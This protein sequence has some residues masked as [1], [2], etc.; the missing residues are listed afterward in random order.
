MYNMSRS[1]VRIFFR[2]M[3]VLDSLTFKGSN[4]SNPL[5]FLQQLDGIRLQAQRRLNKNRQSDWGQFFTSPKI[6]AMMGN[7]FTNFPSTIHLLDAGA[8]VGTLTAA[9]IAQVIESKSGVKEI[10]VTAYELDQ[11]LLYD[12]NITLKKCSEL[13]IKSGVEFQYEIQQK[14]FILDIA[15]ALLKKHTLF[16]EKHIE[17]SHAIMNP[18]YKKI[19]SQSKTR[20]VLNSIGIQTTNLYTAFVWLATEILKPEGEMVV[21]IPRS[22]CNGSY[23]KNFRVHFLRTMAIKQIHIFDSRDNLFKENNVLQENVIV[24][25]KKSDQQI[26]KI[27]ITQSNDPDDD[28]T[29]NFIDY[30]QLVQPDDP[31]FFIRLISNGLE[32]KI[33]STINDLN[34]TLIDLELEVS[35]GR[36]VDFRAEEWLRLESTLETVPLIYPLNIKN[37]RVTWSPKGTKKPSA[38]ISSH[39][40]D[41]LLVPSQNYVLVKRFSSKE[42]KRRV[43]AA[44][45]DPAAINA[46]KIG[47]ENHLNYFYH[48][49]KELSTDFAKG[50]T[51]YLNSTLVD[52]YFRQFSGHTQINASDLRK[53]KYPSQ[54]QLIAMGRQVSNIFP[55]QDEIDRIVSKELELNKE[56][57]LKSQ[58]P[59][60]AKKKIRE[61]LSILK[62][63]NVP[64]AQQNDR[65]ALALL[66]LLNIR[67]DTSW[68][69]ASQNLIGITE[70]MDFFR[71]HY[72]V[73]YAPNTRET[74]RRQTIH[75]FIQLGLVIPNP[76]D[77]TRPINSPKTR[78]VIGTQVMEEI[79]NFESPQWNQQISSFILNT[80]SLQNLQV[81]ERSMPMIPVTLPDGNSLMI[82]SG[83]QNEL[84]K[85]ILEEFCPRFTPGGKVVYIGD[86][87]E[88]LNA[89]EFRYLENL[90]LHIDK[91]GKMPDVI[92][93]QMDRKWLVL[94][95]AVTSHGPIDIKRH[96]ELK[97]LFKGNF[98]LVYITA[99]DTRKTMNRFL[100]DISWETD[101]WVAESPSHLIHFDGERFLGPYSEDKGE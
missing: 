7:M 48:A 69:D 36:V 90:G 71:E 9:F 80:P 92:V 43:Q 57:D 32:H 45:Y 66:A 76:D 100:R 55:V 85:K 78:Y 52:N 5:E 19:N 30:E 101:V 10:F 3:N 95:E 27:L 64:R 91:H 22:F 97:E 67:P 72:G 96:N 26:K 70:M 1:L 18:P 20:Q 41:S 60:L 14:D 77:I 6:A 24:S 88:K 56:N 8:G 21:I 49:N 12:L 75:Q 51:L 34:T 89:K 99:F 40:V 79:R 42:E 47:I 65:S 74:V 29:M 61:A 17:Y 81:R 38:I 73:D 16:D 86:A 50:L 46:K 59:I 54:A 93:H 11:N 62:I 87:G 28:S 13:C 25:A 31:D 44:F 23:Y 37:S 4:F 15:E 84:I 39:E 2:H 63:L 53:L 68:N 35:T 33:S 98:G 82:S 94:I 58:D 83:G